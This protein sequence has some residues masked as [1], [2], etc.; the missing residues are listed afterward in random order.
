MR[1]LLIVGL[2]LAL[3]SCGGTANTSN[4]SLNTCLTK[5][6]YEAAN[7]GTLMSA[8]TKTLAIHISGVCLKQLALE[9]SGL[10]EE[11]VTAATNILTALKAVKSE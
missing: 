7:N 2:A 3:S 6:A 10:N 9:K 4:S 11:T 1:K 8:D 5:K